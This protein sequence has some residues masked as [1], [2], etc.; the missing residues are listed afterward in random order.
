[1]IGFFLWAVA[2]ALTDKNAPLSAITFD[3]TGNVDP[4]VAS[5][6]FLIRCEVLCVFPFWVIVFF[7]FN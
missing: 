1:M 5:F 6:I 2:L 3:F 4:A 7:L